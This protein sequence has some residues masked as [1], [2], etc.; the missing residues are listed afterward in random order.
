[1][2]ARASDPSLFDQEIATSMQTSWNSPA[3]RRAAEEDY[4]AVEYR[5]TEED[6]RAVHLVGNN[7]STVDEALFGSLQPSLN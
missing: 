3:V 7:Y 2:Q 1:M 4:R 6:Y 5:G